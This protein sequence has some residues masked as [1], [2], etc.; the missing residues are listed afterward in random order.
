MKT[1]PIDIEN[2]N[3]SAHTRGRTI[4]WAAVYDPLIWLLSFGRAKS[5]RAESIAHSGIE[6]G[7][8]VL[9]VGCCTGDL[10][11]AVKGSVP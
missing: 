8:S 11:I 1:N 4:P 3:K 6:P 2:H 7:H 9:D 10:T 5:I